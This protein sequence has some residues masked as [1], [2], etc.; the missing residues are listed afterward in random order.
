MTD[1]VRPGMTR[2]ALPDYGLSEDAYVQ[3]AT[4]A[5]AIEGLGILFEGNVRHSLAISHT[6]HLAPTLSCLGRYARVLV[7]QIETTGA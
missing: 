7:D 1:T 3:L 6:E 2:R 4:L 5:A